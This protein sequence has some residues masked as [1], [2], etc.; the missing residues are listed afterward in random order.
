[1]KY[2]EQNKGNINYLTEEIQ[3]LNELHLSKE[4]KI[5]AEFPIG[6]TS[7]DLGGLIILSQ[8]VLA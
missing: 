5:D 7:L 8:R 1:M 4:A 2:I 6:L 3:L